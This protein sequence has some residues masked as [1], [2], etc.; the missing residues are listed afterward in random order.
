M[1]KEQFEFLKNKKILEVVGISQEV[2]HTI[3]LR[4]MEALVFKMDLIKPSFD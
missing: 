3:K 2:L 1:L 4:N